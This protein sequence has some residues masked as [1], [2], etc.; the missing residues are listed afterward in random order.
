MCCGD[1]RLLGVDA[2]G[3]ISESDMAGTAA[4]ASVAGVESVEGREVLMEY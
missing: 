1:F 4:D 2:S 3:D